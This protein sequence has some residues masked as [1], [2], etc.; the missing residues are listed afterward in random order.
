MH[1]VELTIPTAAEAEEALAAMRSTIDPATGRPID[2]ENSRANLALPYIR[3][4]LAVLRSH[5]DVQKANGKPNYQRAAGLF[6]DQ[7]KLHNNA[8]GLVKRWVEKLQALHCARSYQTCLTDVSSDEPASL[9]SA[10]TSE[11]VQ[12]VAAT[13]TSS[14][15][16]VGLLE[17]PKTAAPEE[18]QSVAATSQSSDPDGDLPE[19]L[20]ERGEM[21]SGLLVNPA[22]YQRILTRRAF[23]NSHFFL[24]Q[25]HG[26]RPL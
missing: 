9:P 25:S 4:A 14:D 22:Q 21:S 8:G 26:N 7:T 24:P 18:A 19:L 15:P 23:R 3:A 10:A 17:R 12:S 20:E 2:A 1:S 5:P 11:Q 6:I 13:L 16:D